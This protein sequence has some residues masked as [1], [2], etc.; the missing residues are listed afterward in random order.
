MCAARH[1]YKLQRYNNFG[2]PPNIIP[3]YA[4]FLARH[5]MDRVNKSPQTTKAP[6]NHQFFDKGLSLCSKK[7]DPF[8]VGDC[9]LSA[10]WI[11]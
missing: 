10:V 11:T 8:A 5:K 1:I 9:L 2:N 6:P 3:R 4:L 7:Q